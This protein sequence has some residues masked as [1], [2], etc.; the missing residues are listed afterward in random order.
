[1]D[2]KPYIDTARKDAG[3]IGARLREPSTY[4]GLGALFALCGLSIGGDTA[5]A[6]AA[7]GFAVGNLIGILLPEG[8][9]GA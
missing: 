7:V 8:L 5:H 3:Y 9:N 6:L 4:Q 1:M 2:T